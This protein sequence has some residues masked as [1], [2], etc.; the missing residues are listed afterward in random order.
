M[1]TQVRGMQSLDGISGSHGLSC[2]RRSTLLGTA[3]FKLERLTLVA[4]G[5]KVCSSVS[6][7]WQG[8]TAAFIFEDDEFVIQ[9]SNLLPL[10]LPQG[11]LD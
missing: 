9:T 5:A 6:M 4:S 8:D 11:S 2:G 7:C 3:A 1:R 10:K